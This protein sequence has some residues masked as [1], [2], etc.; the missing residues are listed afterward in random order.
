FY[1]HMQASCIVNDLSID[2]FRIE[3]II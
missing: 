1:E 3:E 2:C